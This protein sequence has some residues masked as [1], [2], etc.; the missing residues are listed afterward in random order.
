MPMIACLT[1]VAIARLFFE[2]VLLLSDPSGSTEA[3]SLHLKDPG[4]RLK[5]L[6]S[7]GY[8]INIP[9]PISQGFRLTGIFH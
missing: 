8:V 4:L 2:L 9:I 6:R 3:R 1:A 7:L 5:G